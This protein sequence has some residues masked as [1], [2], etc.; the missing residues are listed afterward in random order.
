MSKSRMAPIQGTEHAPVAGACVIG[1]SDSHQLIELSVLIKHHQA[2]PLDLDTSRFISHTEFARAFGAEAAHIDKMRQFARDNKL[3]FLEQGDE[4]LRR[5]VKLSGTVVALERAFSVELIEYEHENGS[6]RGHPGPI[7]MPEEY[8]HFVT[9]VFGLDNRQVAEP[10]FRLQATYAAFDDQMTYTAYTPPQVAK[11]YNFPENPDGNGQRIALIE[12]GGGY[13][14]ADIASY[15]HRLELQAPMVKSLS[16]DQANNCPGVAQSADCQVMLDIEM[17][18]AIAPGV[19][20]NIYFAPNTARGLQD[21]LSKAVHDQ[22]NKPSAICI[23]WGAA[24]CNWSG[25]SIQ[26]FNQVA[27]EAAMMGITITSA[28]GDSGSGCGNMDGK[29]HVD[30]PASCPYVLAA[31]GT[32]LTS[33]NG[34]VVSEGAWN[35]GPVIDRVLGGSS[36]LGGVTGGG[37]SNFFAHHPYQENHVSHAGRGVPDVVANAD[38]DTG[39]NILVDGQQM[40]VGGTSAAAALMAGLVIVL[41]QKLNRK[42]G[43]VNPILY[44]LRQSSA[45]HEITTG[46]N[47]AHSASFGWNPVTGLGSPVGMQLLH[48][49]EAPAPD[50]G[51]VEEGI[52]INFETTS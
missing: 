21:A 49:L 44:D 5:T 24:E 10:H 26:N 11:L 28:A 18:G 20:I 48:Q 17:V 30:F 3:N 45:F 2:L 39:Y 46:T 40:L 1:P 13:R 32:R 16:V 25:Q 9:G 42:I 7:R 38:P 6:Y 27:Q 22:L 8:A 43:F 35:N 14:P 23:G 12:L 47:G 37:F 31:G 36:S 34:M 51:R 50:G 29:T 41:N 15:F 4:V 52:P 33:A 19:T